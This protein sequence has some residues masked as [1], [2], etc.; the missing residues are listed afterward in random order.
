MKK[1]I[2]VGT[3]CFIF[4]LA[5]CASQ[6]VPVAKP[7]ETTLDIAV[8]AS[9][10][11]T[12]LAVHFFALESDEQFKRLDYFELMRKKEFKLN[13]NIVITNL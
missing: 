10:T 9:R 8:I 4:L 11:T 12:P 13:G 6:E 7:Q 3:L 2:Y 5:G 1:I